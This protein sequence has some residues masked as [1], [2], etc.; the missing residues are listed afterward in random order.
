MTKA[1]SPLAWSLIRDGALIRIPLIPY[2]ASKNPAETMLGAMAV[3]QRYV[4]AVPNAVRTHIIL[5]TPIED[6]SESEGVEAFRFWLGFA[7]R[8]S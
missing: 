8:L 5:G 2:R 1:D 4:E 3:I 7:A 6:L